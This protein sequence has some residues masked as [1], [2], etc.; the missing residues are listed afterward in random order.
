MLVA[1]VE[2]SGVWSVLGGM[3]CVA[4]AVAARAAAQGAVF[5]YGCAVE[6]IVTHDGAATGVVLESGEVIAADVVISN[7]DVAALSSGLLGK[8]VTTA[9]PRVA[10]SQRSLSAFTL[11][12][13]GS[14]SG[15]PLHRHN[16]FF[17]DDYAREF[18]DIRAR[19]RLPTSPTVY[20]CA[21]DRDDACVASGAPER[22]F[23]IV[24][25]PA[26]GDTHAFTEDETTRCKAAVFALFAKHG[27]DVDFQPANLIGTTPNEFARRFPGAGGALYGRAP[28]GWLSS[29]QRPGVRS[30]IRGLYLAGGSTHPGPG[31]AMA[32]LSGHH[33]A[34]E[35]LKDFP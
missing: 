1:H 29:F 15:F 31:V 13:V 8:S 6:E 20:V 11:A 17:S 18:A 33:A 7:A 25:A 35:V 30:T 28:H 10:A 9:T 12:L 23:C 32:A 19:A 22:L 2:Q 21:Q 4:Q 24:N 16:V 34:I 14:V 27:L 26:N 3:H 5:R